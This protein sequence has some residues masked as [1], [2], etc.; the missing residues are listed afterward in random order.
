M[1]APSGAKAPRG[2]FVYV[3]AEA[4][5]YKAAT[6]KASI[7]GRHIGSCAGPMG[8]RIGSG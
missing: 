4:A 6:Y 2:R 5:T 8:G 3:A 7:V 1:V